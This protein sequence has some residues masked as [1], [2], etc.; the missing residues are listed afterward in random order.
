MKDETGARQW[1]IP[2]AIRKDRPQMTLEMPGP[3][4]AEVR[5][6]M[7]SA[8]AE[9]DL[10]SARVGQAYV[11]TDRSRQVGVF[12]SEK[13]HTGAKGSLRQGFQ[14]ESGQAVAA[15]ARTHGSKRGR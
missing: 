12:L 7:A 2:E 10:A 3:L 4:G 5:R 14:R 6:V 13:V 1:R 15:F 11:P 8:Q 9:R